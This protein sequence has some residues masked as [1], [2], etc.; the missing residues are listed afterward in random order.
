[1]ECEWAIEE[2][3]KTG[4]VVAATMAMAKTGCF[5]GWP[6]GQCAVRMA[7]AGAQVV[8]V[9]CVFDPDGTLTTIKKMKE[10]L[11]AEGLKPF[12]MT[13]PNGFMCPGTGKH[14][15]T[16]CPEYPFAM[17][18]RVCTRIDIH[19]YA[20]AAY[21]LGVRYIGGCCGF[22]AH[23]VRAISEELAKERGRW[24]E[25]SKKHEMWGGGNIHSTLPHVRARVGKD[26]WMSIVPS[27][28]RGPASHPLN[29]KPEDG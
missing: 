11:D 26:Y 9:N 14:G 20:R 15:Y 3:K 8:G 29:P 21:E 27:S 16:S 17:D 2:A 10:A 22:E 23:H 12:L 5:N 24:P 19:K 13:Q 1:V 28:G 4:L 6:P 7:R 25:G 18:S